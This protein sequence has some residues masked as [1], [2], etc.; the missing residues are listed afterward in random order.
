MSGSALEFLAA[1]SAVAGPAF[2]A[3]ITLY[4]PV[5]VKLL[6][7]PNKIYVTRTC[8]CLV[9]IMHACRHPQILSFL[10]GGL[11][12]KSATVRRSC[13]EMVL[14]ALNG[15]KAGAM[16]M[17]KQALEK[18]LSCVEDTIRKGAVDKEVKIRELSRSVWDVYK[19]E[20]P[21]RVTEC[22]VHPTATV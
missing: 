14:E 13:V 3:C 22:V 5:L 18:R 11:D 10:A 16:V 12:D 19:R 21:D 6:A 15:G 17:D 7:R 20:W 1:A 2:S 4:L 9:E 8:N